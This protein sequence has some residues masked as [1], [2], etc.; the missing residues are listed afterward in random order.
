MKRTVV[1]YIMK[2]IYW[3]LVFAAIIMAGVAIIGII[4]ETTPAILGKE[5]TTVNKDIIEEASHI[6]T[7]SFRVDTTG[8]VL[9]TLGP[10][11]WLALQE[12]LADQHEIKCSDC[13]FP[14]NAFESNGKATFITRTFLSDEGCCTLCAQTRARG[15][16]R[17]NKTLQH[18]N[19]VANTI[20]ALLIHEKV[21]Q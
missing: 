3:A 4:N 21:Q 17:F 9:T 12:T 20:I 14:I 13:R 16:E 15:S 7:P 11:K 2:D 1:E 10:E 6:D 5:D 18:I 8:E 19:Y